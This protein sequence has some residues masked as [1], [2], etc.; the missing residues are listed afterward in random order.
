MYQLKNGQE[1]FT[2]AEGPFA[3]RTF[4]PGGLYEEIPPHEAARFAKVKEAEAP[5]APEGDSEKPAKAESEKAV[6][7]PPLS[8]KKGGKS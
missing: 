4:A 2:P 7:D 3:G 1:S 5:A 8:G 6:V